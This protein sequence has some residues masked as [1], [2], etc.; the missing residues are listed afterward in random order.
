MLVACAMQAPGPHRKYCH[1]P[2]SSRGAGQVT[3]PILDGLLRLVAYER[4]TGT[5][6]RV[7]THLVAL[8]AEPWRCGKPA[9]GKRDRVTCCSLPLAKWVFI[10]RRVVC[11]KQKFDCSVMHWNPRGWCYYETTSGSREK[12]GRQLEGHPHTSPP[13]LCRVWRRRCPCFLA[14]GSVFSCFGHLRHDITG[15]Y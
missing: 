1:V 4:V 3:L 2:G 10:T 11:V 6:S 7:A 5:R 14:P 13:D 8:R 9:S 15:K 12:I